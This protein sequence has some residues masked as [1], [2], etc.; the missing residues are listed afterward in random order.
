MILPLFYLGRAL[1]FATEI[2]H[3]VGHNCD[4]QALELDPD[5]W[6]AIS[7]VAG[8]LKAFQSAITEMSKIKEP[9]ILTV[10]AIF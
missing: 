9:M 3:F 6:A 5:D 2:D 7:L 4:L 10:H 8:W 1:D